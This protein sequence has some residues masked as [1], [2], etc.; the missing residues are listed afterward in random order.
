MGC[1]VGLL[2][3]IV[4][5][6]TVRKIGRD[7]DV[8]VNKEFWS[9]AAIGFGVNLLLPVFAGILM[10]FVIG[11][12]TLLDSVESNDLFMGSQCVL[13]IFT[14][15]SIVLMTLILAGLKRSHGLPLIGNKTVPDKSPNGLTEQQ[16]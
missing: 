7:N 15:I 1:I 3:T 9:I 2:F 5:L 12:S 6:T 8:N 16:K 14:L 10:L 13:F 11:K 4:F